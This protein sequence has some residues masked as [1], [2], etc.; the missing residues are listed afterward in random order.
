MA[1][2]DG[3]WCFCRWWKL[4]HFNRDASGIREWLAKIHF[5]RMEMEITWHEFYSTE[6]REL[7]KNLASLFSLALDVN[8]LSFSVSSVCLVLVERSSRS[9]QLNEDCAASTRSTLP[10]YFEDHFCSVVKSYANECTSRKPQRKHLKL[11]FSQWNE[12][13][14]LLYA[15]IDFT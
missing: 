8:W 14:V 4:C 12:N 2:Y 13:S 11:I 9:V 1:N 10:H 7:I 3:H 15:A 5:R 6:K